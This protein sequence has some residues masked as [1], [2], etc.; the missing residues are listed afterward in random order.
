MGAI[1]FPTKWG[2]QTMFFVQFWQNRSNLDF[3]IWKMCCRYFLVTGFN[4]AP[5]IL[6]WGFFWPSLS[7]HR[8]D[9]N[10]VELSL[11][12]WV[13]LCLCPWY[14]FFMYLRNLNIETWTQKQAPTQF[15]GEG[16]SH[17]L[18]AHLLTELDKH[19]LHVLY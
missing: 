4:Q 15:L 9:N 17:D 6:N 18:A 5:P 19:F 13:K 1:I 14:L 3:A 12:L 2:L 11:F 8:E 10:V 16:S 7:V